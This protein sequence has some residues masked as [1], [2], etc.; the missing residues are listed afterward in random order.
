[1]NCSYFVLIQSKSIVVCF[2]RVDLL[3]LTEEKKN[4][5]YTQ[6]PVGKKIHWMYF[7]KK[8]GN[9]RRTVRNQEWSKTSLTS[10]IQ[11]K[12]LKPTSTTK[13]P[14]RHPNRY[15]IL[16]KTKI[17]KRIRKITQIIYTLEILWATFKTINIFFRNAC[18]FACLSCYF[19][20][21]VKLDGL[22]LCLVIL[23][24]F[25]RCFPFLF[26][27]MKQNNLFNPLRTVMVVSCIF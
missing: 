10:K 14:L 18:I 15:I 17:Q 5:I 26:I 20:S 25:I 23:I 6:Y 16:N 3:N 24:M 12:I 13:L 7:I 27:P 8:C 4:N 21:S 22:I 9:E 2:E 19:Y 1:M 11:N